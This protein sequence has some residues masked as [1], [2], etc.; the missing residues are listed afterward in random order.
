VF[1]HLG[2]GSAR[3]IISSLV[4]GTPFD[5]I[6]ETA[7][8]DPDTLRRV[9]LTARGQGDGSSEVVAVG[10]AET[11]EGT[12]GGAA[13]AGDAYRGRAT[14]PLAHPERVRMM[15]GWSSPGKPTSQAAGEAALAAQEA[16]A[17][18]AAAAADATESA[19]NAQNPGAGSVESQPANSNS[20]SSS[21]ATT[22][23]STVAESDLP[24]AA[25]E[26]SSSNSA[27]N[28]NDQSGVGQSIQNMTRMFEQR[29]QIQAQQ[30]QP[31]PPSSN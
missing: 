9:V 14:E 6:V 21:P 23:A 15:P 7:E 29:R 28:S 12:S 5:Y 2:P 24:P 19:A 31:P 27:S 1:I 10:A 8:D 22:P 30:N 11:G 4:Y 17:Q 16:A 13:L 25:P 18:D 3:D 20:L 26:E